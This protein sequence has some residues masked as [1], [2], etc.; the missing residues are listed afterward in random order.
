MVDALFALR[1]CPKPAVA[2]IRGPGTGAGLEIAVMCDIRIAARS[3]R[4]GVPIQ[5][6]G[7]TMP[8]PELGAFLELVGRATLLE[9]LLEGRVFDADEALAKRLVSRVVDDAERSE[10]HT[11]ELQSLM[12]ISYAVFCLKKKKT[13]IHMTIAQKRH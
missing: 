6:L 4:F 8:Y 12:R 5:K 7:V 11:S 3:A 2:R 1:D 13:Q 10:E 9:I